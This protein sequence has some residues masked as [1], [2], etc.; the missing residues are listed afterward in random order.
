M[1]LHHY[2]NAPVYQKNNLYYP[3]NLIPCYYTNKK[4]YILYKIFGV[5]YLY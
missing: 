5:F 3:N 4:V 1:F 2:D